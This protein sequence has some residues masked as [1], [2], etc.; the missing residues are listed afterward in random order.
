[1]ENI[2]LIGS[3]GHAKVL[4]DIVER[5]GRYRIAGLLDSFKTPGDSTLGYTVL[6]GVDDLPGLAQQYAVDGL[7]IA[8]GDNYVRVQMAERLEQLCPQ[9]PLVTAIHPAAVIGRNVSL[10]SGSVVMAGAVLNPC[11]RVGRLCIMNTRASLDHDSVLG[12][13]ASLAPGAVTGGGALIG[14][15]TAVGAG[16]VVLHRVEIGAHSVIGAGA[17]VTRNIPAGV[18]AY[19]CPAKVVR[20]RER[21][22]RYL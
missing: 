17:V 19:G 1:M 21:G 6:G 14:A 15:E 11:C 2:F 16:A 8:I 9:L 5:E 4:I 3:S 18:V 20:Q 13:G 22:E 10:G 7:L 12:D